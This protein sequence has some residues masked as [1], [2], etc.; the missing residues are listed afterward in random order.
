M[1]DAPRTRPGAGDIIGRVVFGGFW[2]AVTLGAV[3]FAFSSFSGGDSGPGLGALVI[4]ALTGLYARYI[5][6]GGRI[7]FL[8][9]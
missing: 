6:R 8:S 2:S 4:A 9:F 7:R 5:F 1:S 3:I